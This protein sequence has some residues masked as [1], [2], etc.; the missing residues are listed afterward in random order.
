MAKQSHFSFIGPQDM[1]LKIKANAGQCMIY[2]L[3]SFFFLRLFWNKAFIF[4]LQPEWDAFLMPGS[5]G[6]ILKLSADFFK[7]TRD[8]I[9]ND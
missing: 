3:F 4:T 5:H 7:K 2:K 1:S 9:N 6:K 8:H